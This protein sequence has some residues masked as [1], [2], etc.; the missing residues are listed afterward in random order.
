MQFHIPAMACDGCL[1]SITLA[2][3]D[4]D[5]GARVTGDLVQRRVEV[6]SDAPR[7][8][9]VSVLSGIGYSPTM[10]GDV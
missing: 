2:I 1:R 3:R 8:R 9:L 5:P 4:V 6:S 10:T 7:E